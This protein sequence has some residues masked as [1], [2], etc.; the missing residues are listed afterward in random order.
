MTQNITACGFHA[1]QTVLDWEPERII[2]VSLDKTRRDARMSALHQQLNDHK[3]AFQLVDKNKLERLSN[4]N[5]HQGVVVEL[6]VAAMRNENDLLTALDN[7]PKPPL[8]MVLDQIQDP[9]NFGAC[10]RTADAAGVDGVII[11]KDNSV[12]FTPTVLKTSTGAFEFVPV[13]QVTNLRRL[14]KTLQNRGVWIVGASGDAK[15]T[16]YTADLKG[17]L[18]I[19]MG[20]EGSGMRRLTS[21]ACDF[22]VSIPMLGRVESLNVSVATGVILYEALRQRQDTN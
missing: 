3:I 21:E 18:A 22:L 2:S 4:S 17:A 14:L 10:L 7:N 11:A 15:Q 8:L 13:Y 9:H 1:I 19:V 16:I 6:N 20:S 12:G 5:N